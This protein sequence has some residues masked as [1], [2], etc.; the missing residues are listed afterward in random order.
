[1]LHLVGH[2]EP[3]FK[4]CGDTEG[5]VPIVSPA[6]APDESEC[7]RLLKQYH[8]PENVIAHCLAVSHKAVQIAKSLSIELDMEMVGAAA[9][10]HDIARAEK[11]HAEAGYTHLLRCGYPKVAAIVR[12]H[13]RL[14]PKDLENVTESTIVFYADKLVMETKEVTLEERFKKSR[15]S[16]LTSE[17]I[18][19]HETQYN[20]ALMTRDLID[21]FSHRRSPE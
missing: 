9:L 14:E 5:N 10:L 1:L 3:E 20:Q 8:T 21:R 12:T 19:S 6:A 4:G 2:D 11:N 13:H 7:M 15:E 17:A 16:C 18:A